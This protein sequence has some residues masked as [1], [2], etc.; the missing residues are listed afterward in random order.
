MGRGSSR[1]THPGDDAVRLRVEAYPDGGG[2]A[3]GDGTLRVPMEALFAHECLRTVWADED[4]RARIEKYEHRE[5]AERERVHQRT[6]SNCKDGAPMPAPAL[7]PVT[8]FL[9]Y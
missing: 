2:P 5:A 8:K 6:R 4:E 3:R 9:S 1:A 7:S